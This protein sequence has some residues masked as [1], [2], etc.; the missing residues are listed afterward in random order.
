M[1]F[2]NF[3]KKHWIILVVIGIFVFI[4]GKSFLFSINSSEFNTPFLEM[5]WNDPQL[6]KDS[7]IGGHLFVS[8][9]IPES[10]SNGGNFNGINAYLDNF[11][12]GQVTLPSCESLAFSRN[13]DLDNLNP[14]TYQKTIK[15]FPGIFDITFKNVDGS[16]LSDKPNTRIDAGCANINSYTSFAVQRVECTTNNHCV[17]VELLAAGECVNNKCTNYPSASSSITT[18]VST[19]VERTSYGWLIY[20]GLALIVYLIYRRFRRAF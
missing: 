13:I 1:A 7:V 14:K 16:L 15:S 9:C 6:I 3:I 12:I 18:K 4:F 17:D 11:Y 8:G 19:I 10:C 5:Q 2:N 20:T